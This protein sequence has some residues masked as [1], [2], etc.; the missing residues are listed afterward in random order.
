MKKILII[1]DDETIRENAQFFL[2]ENGFK[3]EVAIDGTVGIQKA[4][5]FMPNLIISDITMPKLNGYDV[6]K[7]LQQISSTSSI[8]FIFLSAKTGL[9]DIRTGLQLGVDDYLTKPVKM[10][11]LLQTIN[12]RLEKY[13]KIVNSNKETYES[14]FENPFTGVFIYQD[15]KFIYSN[16]K[17][18]DILAYTKKEFLDLGIVDIVYEKDIDIVIK[19]L[20]DCLAG[21]IPNFQIQFRAITSIGSF[22]YL[23]M[24]ANKST[25]NNKKGLMGTVIDITEEKK[26]GIQGL[27][28][29]QTD[30]EELDKAFQQITEGKE[31]SNA[32]YFK[33]LKKSGT[34]KLTKREIQILKLIAFGM[35]NNEV[36]KELS[37]SERTVDWHRTNILSKTN[38]KNR[39][40][41]TKFAIRNKYIEI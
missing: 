25:L 15:H 6:Y 39:T 27:L 14:V 19:S 33:E 11:D 24:Y 32:K 8:P 20:D 26:A 1:K 31:I 3:V 37:I 12:R 4:L 28:L 9:Q 35:T 41:L 10:N 23:E 34:I 30:R 40:E 13:E 22:I 36:S 17:Y 7:T 38:T 21:T 16:Q 5:E 18:L 29:R 2:E